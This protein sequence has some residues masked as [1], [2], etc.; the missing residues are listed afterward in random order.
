MKN[1]DGLE[2]P[3]QVDFIMAAE[4]FLPAGV[5]QHSCLEDVF[6]ELTLI[7]CR[8]LK[9]ILADGLYLLDLLDLW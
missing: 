7:D 4:C 1:T 6:N 9:H 2:I 8:Q 3:D 5:R